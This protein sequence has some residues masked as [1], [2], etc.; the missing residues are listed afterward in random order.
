MPELA[1]PQQKPKV[2]RNFT[3]YVLT[4]SEIRSLLKAAW[5]DRQPSRSVER[6][7]LRTLILVVYGTGARIGEVL[8]LQ[9][10]DIDTKAGLITIRKKAFNRVREIPINRDLHEILK[11]YLAWRLRQTCSNSDLFVTKRGHTLTVAIANKHWQR[12]RRSVNLVR[13]D[14]T[15]RKPRFDDLRSTFA[16]HRITSWIRNG[17]DLNRMLPALAAYMGQMGL[18]A[19]ER[20]LHMTP[21]RF[22]KDLNKLSPIHPRGRWRDDKD[23]MQ[24]LASL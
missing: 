2:R 10:G 1:M 9:V 15:R 8:S 6:E 17:A 5:Q 18:G 11:K 23:L 13:L 22:R 24:F 14:E 7:C 21:E 3:P 12:L 20:Y 16:V 19:T 4:R